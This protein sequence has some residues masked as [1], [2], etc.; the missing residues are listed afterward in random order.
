MPPIRLIA[1]DLDGTLL[2]SQSVVS[3]GNREALM[4]ATRRGAQIVVV[5]GRRFHS[6]KPFVDQIPCPATVISSNGARIATCEGEV[7]HRNFLPSTI[8]RRIL[9]IA[10]EYLAYT[11]AIFDVPGRGQVTMHNDAVPEGPLG[12]YLKSA[13][14]YLAQVHNLRQALDSDPIQIMFGGP[15]LR[16]EPL[17]PVLRSSSAAG[18]VHLTWTKYPARNTSLLDVMNKGCSKGCA[19][20]LWAKRC[21]IERGEVMAMGDNFNDVEMLEFAGHPVV[22]A[23]YTPGFV[24]PGW[25]VTRSNDEDG[26]ALAIR[27]F[28][29]NHGPK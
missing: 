16:I 4:E 19:L 18:S 11:V 17:E 1:V 2:D 5:T 20:A 23:N 13:P 24:R 7:L 21:G 6:A 8:A 3:P 28:V 27:E 29:L 22:M 9:E 15:P 26:V 10:H 12:W 14:E 25:T